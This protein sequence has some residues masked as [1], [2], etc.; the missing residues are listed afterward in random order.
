MMDNFAS[1]TNIATP[2]LQD[3]TVTRVLVVDSGL[4]DWQQL[5]AKAEAGTRVIILD[6]HSDGLDQLAQALQGMRGIETLSVMSHGNEGLLVLGNTELD[7]AGLSQYA[8]QLSS[9][10]QA[11]SA[12]G[13]IAFFGC[14]VGG[15][16]EGQ[17]FIQALAD[18][19]GAD[20]AASADLTGAEKLGGDWDLEIRSGTIE[21]NSLSAIPG[22]ADYNFVMATH[23]VSTLAGLKSAIASDINNGED[24]TI[25]LTSDITFGSSSDTIEL[26]ITDGK[27]ITIVGGNHTIDGN[28]LTQI[29]KVTSGSVEIQNLTITK[30]LLS[31]NGGDAGINGADANDVGG[32]GGDALGAAIYNSGTLTISGSTITNSKAA[33]GGGGGGLTTGAGGGGGGGGGYGTTPGGKG[34]SSY[35]GLTKGSLGTAGNG[36]AGGASG[37][38]PGGAGGSSTGGAGGAGGVYTSGG[39]GASA[40]Y[41]SINIGGG[42]GGAGGTSTGG[43]GGNAVGGIYNTGT[44]TITNSSI[45]NNLGAG[46]GGGGGGGSGYKGKPGGNGGSGIGGL[47]NNGGTVNID[48]TSKSSL[49]TGNNGSGGIGGDSS[50]TA[51]TDGNAHDMYSGTLTN[52]VS[53]PTVTLSINN[54]SIAEAAGT[55]TVTAT[56]SAAAS[57]DTTVTLTA[58]GTATG[59][60]YTLSSN[61]ITIKAGQTTG[62]TTVTA[63][64]DA[65]DEADETVILDITGV[66]GGDSATESGTQQQTVTITDD[67][68]AAPAVVSVVQTSGN[69]Y[70]N[71]G[72]SVTLTI[73]F[74][75]AVTVTGA[76]RLQ[77]ETGTTDQYATYT[78]GSG[79]TTLIFTYTVQ[80]GDTS[81]DLQYLSTSALELNTGTIVA[82]SGGAAATLTL[83]ATNSGNSLGELSAVIIDTTAPNVSGPDLV[84]G[85]DSGTSFTDDITSD[86]TPTV[87]GI[88]EAYA[89]ITLYDSDGTTVLGTTTAD[90]GGDWSITSTSL[91]EGQHS[92][93]TTV[94][95]QAGN[96]SSLSTGL[97]VSIDI[98]G[99]VAPTGLDL[100]AASDSGYYNNDNITYKTTPTVN[101]FAQAGS[102][103]TLYD[104]NGTSVLGTTTTNG[105]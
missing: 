82:T 46:G 15:G 83:P 105:L 93:Q 16:A 90:G 81:S 29:L 71:A 85:S 53:A 24:D 1:E 92:L 88:S 87:S 60:D 43:V 75:A 26:K 103:I 20:V 54:A 36:G 28:N 52:Y 31:G 77:L 95:D 45:T 91:T 65:V 57:T 34:G 63:V 23:S 27:K 59:S 101:G 18:A 11:M 79:S 4:P 69:G 33:G 22:M 61:T 19:T 102:T 100:A 6:Q 72:D 17:A 55:S 74:D 9:I 40:A 7:M 30:G 21:S 68:I 14:N 96:V 44:L 97:T 64:Q 41:G 49:A 37:P 2:A 42:G 78:S 56:L 70:Y 66:S 13:D 47:W 48:S 80:A 10:G 5:A 104:T 51:G 35:S 76:P 99:A 62:T 3:T 38:A 98:T 94:T 84:A 73:T 89:S 32:A 67:D 86:T 8:A 12:N 25:T 58:T 39:A 50:G